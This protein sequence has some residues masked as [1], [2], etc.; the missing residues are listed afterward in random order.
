MIVVDCSAVV[1]ILF[2]EPRAD[3]LLVRLAMDPVR[4][5]SVASHLETGTVLA[6]R[7]QSDRLLAIDDLDRFLDEA[8]DFQ[9]SCG[10][11][12]GG[13][14]FVWRKRGSLRIHAMTA[15]RR[16][17]SLRRRSVRFCGGGDGLGKR[18]SLRECSR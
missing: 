15:F 5:M 3:A 6:G 13:I 10:G 9:S 12:C 14:G 7:R 1:A 2:G 16:R 8:E 11:W 17:G 18:G 4:V